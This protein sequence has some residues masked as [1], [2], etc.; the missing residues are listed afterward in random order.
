[1]TRP[2]VVV[3]GGGVGGL[4]AV[5][6]LRAHLAG[7]ADLIHLTGQGTF[8]YRPW[9]T[10]E[11]FGRGA[12][13]GVDLAGMAA[14]LGIELVVD[15]LEAVDPEAKTLTTSDGE[16]TY[17]QLV[18]ALGAV[19]VEIVEGA[20]TFRGPENAG[21]LR[22]RLEARPA[23][24]AFVTTASSVWPLPAYELALLAAATTDA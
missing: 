23:S 19:P 7:R 4:E 5:L 16:L 11:V 24:I 10:G 12:I 18:L 6:A 22:E 20:F 21:E 13:V 15:T 2:R 14:D 3:A 17:D 9:A 1:V 8:I